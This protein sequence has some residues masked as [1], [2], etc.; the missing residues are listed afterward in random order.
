MEGPRSINFNGREKRWSLSGATALVTG[1][2]KGI[3]YNLL[4]YTDMFSLEFL[5][6][7]IKAYLLMILLGACS[8]I[9]NCNSISNASTLDEKKTYM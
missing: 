2:T 4:N 1:G 8:V 3:G 5:F 7:L 9:R 6:L